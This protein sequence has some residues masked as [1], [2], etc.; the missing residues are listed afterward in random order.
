MA[1][2]NT[3]KY[4]SYSENNNLFIANTAIQNAT[5]KLPPGV[6]DLKVNPNTGQLYYEMIDTNCDEIIE[7][8]SKEFKS[9][10][11]QL[12][13]FLTPECKERFKEKK[14]LYKRSTL[15]HGKPGTGKTVIINRVIEHVIKLNG[16]VL[17]NPIPAFLTEVLTQLQDIQPDTP[18][19]VVFEELDKLMRNYEGDLLSILDGEVQKENVIFLATTNFIGQIPPR[20]KR[21]GRFNNLIE[22]SFPSPEVRQFYLE[23][24]L[25]KDYPNLNKWV[26]STNGFSIDELSET[27]R[28][29]YCLNEDLKETI[30][31]IK[32]AKDEAGEDYRSED[33]PYDIMNRE[34]NSADDSERPRPVRKKW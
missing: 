3:K 16:V 24:K 27:V 22:V 7:L 6:Y 12:E 30:Q 11:K 10:I 26:E 9:V 33:N 25:G 15:I 28:Q 5:E 17:F 19:I 31:R 4:V 32:S 18:I 29:V 13:L 2:K 8:P 20:I 14:F 23:H 21:P 34:F 1:K